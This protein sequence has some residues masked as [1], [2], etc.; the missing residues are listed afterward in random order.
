MGCE[1]FRMQWQFTARKR[2]GRCNVEQ[3]WGLHIYMLHIY[4]IRYTYM[5]A[6]YICVLL[7]T[8]RLT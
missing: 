5:R 6:F 1:R 8:T 2:N 7:A 3:A 4:A